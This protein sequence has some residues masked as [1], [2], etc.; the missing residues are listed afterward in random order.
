M[1]TNFLIVSLLSLA[2]CF[3]TCKS[4]LYTADKLPE[5]Q[6]LFGS[7]GGF[8]GEI[9]EYILLENGQLFKKSSIKNTIL[10]MGSIKKRDAKNLLKEVT[11]LQLDKNA[12]SK[13]G[14]MSYFVCLKNG[15][16]EHRSTWGNPNYQADSTL[17]A[18]YQKLMAA[19][20]TAQ[21]PTK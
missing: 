17:E 2:F 9:T 12:V 8:S 6:L 15:S 18:T 11:S 7:G 21:A 16:T 14:N 5:Q 20:N 10:E 3:F 13:P 4:Q 19:A 1:K